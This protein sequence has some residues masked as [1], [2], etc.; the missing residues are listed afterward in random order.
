MNLD[1]WRTQLR[2][3]LLD[4][5]VLN[6][7]AGR[8]YYGYDLVQELKKSH[9]LRIREGTVYPILARLEEDGLVISEVRPSNTG[10]PRKYFKITAEGRRA[11]AE[12]NEHWD[13]VE[14]AI[15][16]SMGKPSGGER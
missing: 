15:R 16:H 11:V 2:K 6:F 5:C 14:D 1:N 3:G 9:A 8:E 4:L 12:M 7:L 13:W 10:P